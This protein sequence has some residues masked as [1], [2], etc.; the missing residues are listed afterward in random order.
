[1]G[2]VP[3]TPQGAQGQA[4]LPASPGC[5]GTI[6][7]ISFILSIRAG[8]GEQQW[9]WCPHVVP[10]LSCWGTMGLAAFSLHHHFQPTPPLHSFP[11]APSHMA[12]SRG[13]VGKGRKGMEV[14]GMAKGRS[15]GSWAAGSDGE[16]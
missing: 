13:R 11:P 7:T 16:V 10:L 6:G 12:K 2:P 3:D 1:M 15:G 5:L 9:V 4:P 14:G 8:L